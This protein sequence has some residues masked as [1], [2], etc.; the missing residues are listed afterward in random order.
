MTGWA[1]R[2][3]EMALHEEGAKAICTSVTVRFLDGR[4]PDIR[5]NV[6]AGADI[7]TL[8][9]DSLQET[10]GLVPV[11]AMAAGLPVVMPDWDGFRDTVPH[12][13]AGFRIPTR[14]PGPGPGEQMARR[15]ADETDGYMQYL[16]L[17]QSAVQIDVP[18]Y[19][20]AIGR[21][22]TDAD[23]RRRMGAEAA[24]HARTTY[25]WAAVIPL[26][27]D[28]AAE[29]ADRRRSAAVSTPPLASGPLSPIEV[30]PFDL[31]R[32]Y[33]TA[34]LDPDET[35]QP[36]LAA[37][38]ALLDLIDRISG[39]QLYRR[40]PL[41]RPLLQ[42]VIAAVA[43]AGRTTPRALAAA[44]GEPPAVIALAVLHLAKGDLVRL[45]PIRPREPPAP[46][47]DV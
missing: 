44:L 8:P 25:D 16:C 27:R 10:F 4:D 19:A 30:D 7:F 28:L 35:V 46:P 36:G 21:L 47:E 24:R 2:P 12:G 32:D 11:E 43:K 42:R 15:F 38:D 41:P 18:L 1:S 33:P 13:R 39:R 26:Y 5:R 23:L 22:A 3:E 17:A 20:A 9:A 29:L 45:G 40:A 31:Y 37:S 6:W 14:M 34:T